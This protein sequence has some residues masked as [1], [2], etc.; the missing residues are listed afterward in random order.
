MSK[1]VTTYCLI[2]IA[3][4]FFGIGAMYFLKPVLVSSMGVFE[5]EAKV[6][7]VI[8]ELSKTIEAEVVATQ[9][10]SMEEET[11]NDTIPSVDTNPLPEQ[12]IEPE[13]T[14]V[15]EVVETPD[16]VLIISH[17][18]VVQD[19]NETFTVAGIRAKDVGTEVEFELRDDENHRYTSPDGNFKEVAGN[20]K[21]V[22]YASVKD[23]ATGKK[24]SSRLAKGF[25]VKK[26]VQKM[27][28]SEVAAM[29]NTGNAD[30]F[31]KYRDHFVD[32]PVIKSNRNNISAM[33]QV[34]QC[35][36]MEF[37]TVSVSDLEYDSLG[38]IVSLTVTI[39]E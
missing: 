3:S 9:S 18:S 1:N 31:K 33:S 11:L 23:L 38:R 24:S 20:A 26:P 6:S 14:P 36:S 37:M 12:N 30:S 15:E 34:F 28:A 17:I 22:Y 5:E 35:V 25:I 16:P 8:A 39:V 29:F 13:V 2:A 21:G 32:K 19:D 7:D 27:E 4:I 10:E